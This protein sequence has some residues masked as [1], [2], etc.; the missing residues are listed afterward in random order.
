M[1]ATAS[2]LLHDASISIAISNNCSAAMPAAC[3][4]YASTTDVNGCDCYADVMFKRHP[5]MP[6]FNNMRS[7]GSPHH[8]TVGSLPAAACRLLVSTLHC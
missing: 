5:H 2:L 4:T 8:V 7:P 3:V 6:L 1:A